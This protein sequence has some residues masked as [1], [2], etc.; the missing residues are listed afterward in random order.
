MTISLYPSEIAK[1]IYVELMLK[2]QQ[3]WKMRL[4]HHDTN[5][6]IVVA[7]IELQERR[8][9]EGSTH[10]KSTQLCTKFNG[11]ALRI[12][13]EHYGFRFGDKHETQ[14]V[15]RT[16]IKGLVLAGAGFTE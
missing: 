14:S 6:R 8:F 13:L 3:L 2:S 16:L 7:V 11:Q 12:I 9:Y 15:S 4:Y 1:S 5:L 10:A